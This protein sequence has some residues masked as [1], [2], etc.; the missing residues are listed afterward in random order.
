MLRNNLSDREIKTYQTVSAFSDQQDRRPLKGLS[1]FSRKG[2]LVGY[3]FNLDVAR[4]AEKARPVHLASVACNAE[5]Y[6]ALLNR[7]VRACSRAAL[8]FRSGGETQGIEQETRIVLSI[9]PDALLLE[10]FMS[11]LSRCARSLEKEGFRLSVAF[12][13]GDLVYIRD[14]REFRHALYKLADANLDVI[15]RNPSLMD[16]GASNITVIERAVNMVSVTP[17]WLGMGTSE[18]T[19]DHSTYFSQVTRLSTAIHEGGHTVICEGIVN[20]WQ[21]SFI[22]SLP[23]VYFSPQQSG[24]DVYV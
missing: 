20:D 1:L 14:F 21:Q 23:I 15:I 13:A 7:I 12:E 11:A 22:S 19:F 6:I 16:A 24:E 17:Q 5:S 4:Q 9:R 18:S 8:S 2:D 10:R 3:T